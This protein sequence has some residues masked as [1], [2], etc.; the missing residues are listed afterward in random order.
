MEFP[1]SESAALTDVQRDIIELLELKGTLSR[2]EI[3]GELDLSGSTL[4]ENVKKLVDV[5]KLVEE[6]RD[7]TG[8]CS[9]NP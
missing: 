9:L 5:G 3:M 4:H 2:P 8:Y 1:G 7:G 6:M